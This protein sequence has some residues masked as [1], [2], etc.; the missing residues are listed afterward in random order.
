MGPWVHVG[1][2]ADS[3]GVAVGRAKGGDGP[4]A[5]VAVGGGGGRREWWGAEVVPVVRENVMRKKRASTSY[6]TLGRINVWRLCG[7]NVGTRNLGSVLKRTETR[8]ACSM[9]C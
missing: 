4:R 1:T 9:R 6:V 8:N 2:Q 7:G 5:G 3:G